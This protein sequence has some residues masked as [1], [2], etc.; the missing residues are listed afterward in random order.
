[1]TVVDDGKLLI[2]KPTFVRVI[3]W[4][5]IVFFLFSATGAWLAGAQKPA[6]FF[7][8]F[9]SLGVYMLLFSGTLEMNSEIIIFR[10]PLMRYQ[11]R[12]DEVTRLELDRVGSSI[13]FW[14]EN[15]RLV[16]MGPYYWQ[17]AD[18][19]DMLLL[20][21]AQIDKLGITQEQSERAMFR[22]SKNTRVRS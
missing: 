13:V 7:L 12:W 19:K 6:L 21:A 8:V 17:G 5:C 18:K 15:K 4:I 16:G 11:M 3:G 20:V 22:R 9:V 1:M 14:G 10:T 2:V